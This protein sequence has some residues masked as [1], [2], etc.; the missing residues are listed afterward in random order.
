MPLFS[1]GCLECSHITEELFFQGEEVTE[2]ID[3]EN[4]ESKALK[5][6]VCNVTV[7]GADSLYLEQMS[8]AHFT[9]Q[10]LRQG[11][12]FK[13]HRE[14]SQFE[15]NKKMRRLTPG[16]AEYRAVH[17]AQLDEDQM[18]KRIK[19]ESGAKGLAE[20]FTKNDIQSKLGWSDQ[21]YKTWKE[22]TDGHKSA[23]DPKRD[24]GN[25]GKPA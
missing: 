6:S 24:A 19:R 12:S 13:S 7:I 4:C 14:L 18:Y 10:E 3:C 8:K 1:Y 9:K 20:H 11:K 5:M 22:K 21:R 2:V 25:V 17:E 23:Y 16:T 15:D